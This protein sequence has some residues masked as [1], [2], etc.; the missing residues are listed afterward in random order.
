MKVVLFCGGKGT[1]IRAASESIPKPLLDVAGIPI[2][3]RLM[4][5]YSSIGATEFILAGGYK[6]ELIENYFKSLVSSPNTL[7]LDHFLQEKYGAKPIDEWDI[8]IVDTGECNI[9]TRLYKLK[10][11]LIKEDLFLANYS[12]SVSDIDLQESIDIVVKNNSIAASAS[13]KPSQYYHWLEH[14]DTNPDSAEGLAIKNIACSS[15]LEHRINGGY[16]CLKPDIF[17]YMSFGEELVEEPFVRLIQEKK[18]L[19][20]QTNAYWRSIDTYKDLLDAESELHEKG[21]NY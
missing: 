3:T 10:D 18:L 2:I 9:G 19:G 7:K 16:M 12:D 15:L 11:Y 1:R 6:I 5:R 4:A 8:N 20:Y 21:L 13:V 14:G 17:K